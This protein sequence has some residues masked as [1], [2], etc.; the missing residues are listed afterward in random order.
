MMTMQ[1]KDT[2]RERTDSVKKMFVLCTDKL[3]SCL[4][5]HDLDALLATYALRV[6]EARREMN[7]QHTA[8]EHDD[9]VQTWH[10]LDNICGALRIE[11]ERRWIFSGDFGD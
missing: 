3:L 11:Q 6:A 2:E 7:Q 9:L 4:S 5:E 1:A 10:I 8:E